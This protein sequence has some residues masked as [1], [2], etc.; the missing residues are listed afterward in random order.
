[1]TYFPNATSAE[2][3]M[4]H[5]CLCRNWKIRDG[6]TESCPIV[7]AHYEGNY[8][9]CRNKT[10]KRILEILWPT[11]DG[12][13]DKCSMFEHNGECKGQLIFKRL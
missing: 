12:F 6:E 8:K 3:A 5:C 4:E 13:P 2:I 11:K 10:I 7:D 9:Q 1:M